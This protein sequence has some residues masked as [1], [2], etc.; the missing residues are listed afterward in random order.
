MI[1]RYPPLSC[2]G[3]AL[4]YLLIAFWR[5]AGRGRGLWPSA[6]ATLADIGGME[7]G[8]KEDLVV[9]KAAEGDEDA[10]AATRMEGVRRT[11]KVGGGRVW[12]R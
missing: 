10:K 9:G 12:A 2:Q 6:C 5:P 3:L 7:D 8:E 4:P 1:M 11:R